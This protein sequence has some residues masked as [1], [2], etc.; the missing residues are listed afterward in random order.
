MIADVLTGVDAVECKL[1]PTAFDRRRLQRLLSAVR[2]LETPAKRQP[3]TRREYPSDS[4]ILGRLA[5][6]EHRIVKVSGN[7]GATRP[8]AANCDGSGGPPLGTNAVFG[9]PALIHL[10]PIQRGSGLGVLVIASCIC[11]AVL[12]R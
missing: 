3:R 2:S 11:P 5:E 1:Q 6:A 10:P 9:A 8:P 12:T 4:R 7:H